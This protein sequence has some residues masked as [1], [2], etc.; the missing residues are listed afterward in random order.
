MQVKVEPKK[1]DNWT[2]DKKK[3]ALKQRIG[4]SKEVKGSLF[5]VECRYVNWNQPQ[6][7]LI[8]GKTLKNIS[9]VKKEV[10]EL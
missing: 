2:P 9:D 6:E 7:N 5:T 3:V 8:C 4:I 10:L 1:V